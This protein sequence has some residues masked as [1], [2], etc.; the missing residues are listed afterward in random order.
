M[1]KSLIVGAYYFLMLPALLGVTF[2]TVYIDYSCGAFS[3]CSCLEL[4]RE[5]AMQFR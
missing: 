1:S 5:T 2:H 4:S 3:L